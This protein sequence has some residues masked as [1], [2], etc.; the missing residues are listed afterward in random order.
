MARTDALSHTVDGLAGRM[1]WFLLA[2]EGA[3]RDGFLQAVAPAVKLPGLV[4]LVVLAVTRPA[5]VE[6]AA[7]FG[8]GVALGVGSQVP[9]RAFAGRVV[10]PTAVAAVVVAPQAV[11]LA[12]PPV[13][14][15]PLTT[16]GV[17]YVALFACRV[18]AGAAFLALLVLTTRVSALLAAARRLRVPPTAVALV[19][20]TYRYLLVFFAEL[21]RM[22]RARRARTVGSPTL[23]E[24]WRDSGHFT[25]TFLVRTLERGERVQRAARA[26]GGGVAGYDRGRTLGGA[27]LAFGAVVVAAAT[28]VVLA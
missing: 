16:T 28:A 11:L 6:A 23:R 21:Q 8:L 27:D 24:T 13:V 10:G 1:R 4:A 26:R 2:E 20:V 14:D 17:A 9:L 7:L 3:R 5:I 25:S 22:V 15:T 19:A 18:G 12:G